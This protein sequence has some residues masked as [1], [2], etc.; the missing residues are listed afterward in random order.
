MPTRFTKKKRAP[1][2]GATGNEAALEAMLAAKKAA[3]K[4]E[5][6]LP[7]REERARF[8]AGIMLNAAED[9]RDRLKA[10]ELLSKMHS[11]FVEKHELSGPGGAPM[12][13]ARAADLSDDQLAAI[14][15]RALLTGNVA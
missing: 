1:K 15:G 14:A 11:D 4:D 13:L 6:P 12:L 9:I 2:S 7:T 5:T 8:F 10:A 3:P